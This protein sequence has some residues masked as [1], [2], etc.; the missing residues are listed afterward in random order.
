MGPNSTMGSIYVLNPKDPRAIANSL[1][2]S[3][4]CP[5]YADTEGGNYT[6]TWNNLYLPPIAKRINGLLKGNLNFT[7]SDVSIFPTLCTYETAITGKRSQW[8]N[9]FS[10]SELRDFEYAQDLRYYYGHGMH[11]V[12]SLIFNF[13]SNQPFLKALVH[14]R[15]AQ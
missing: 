6:A 2:P 1:G 15:M 14:S 10:D 3:D 11:I 7:A 9:V 12:N 13:C 5:T 4:A 8:C